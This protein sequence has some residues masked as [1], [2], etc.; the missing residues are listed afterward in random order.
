MPRDT[1][2]I[3]PGRRFAHCHPLDNAVLVVVSYNGGER[4]LVSDASGKNQR[5]VFAKDLRPSAIKSNGEE[6][7]TGYAPA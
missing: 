5:T 7:K 2:H 1:S 6:Y 3:Q 4:V